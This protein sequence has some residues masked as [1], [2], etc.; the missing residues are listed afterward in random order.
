[1]KIVLLEFGNFGDKMYL[2]WISGFGVGGLCLV[3]LNFEEVVGEEFFVLM[4]FL[5]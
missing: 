1:M 2:I 4:L 5:E 3:F